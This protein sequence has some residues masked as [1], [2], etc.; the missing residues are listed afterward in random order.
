M[1]WIKRININTNNLMNTSLCLLIL[2]LFVN[3]SSKY[4]DDGRIYVGAFA[5]CKDASSCTNAC[6]TNQKCIQFRDNDGSTKNINN[7]PYLTQTC[8]QIPSCAEF[9]KFFAFQTDDDCST[10]CEINIFPGFSLKSELNNN[11]DLYN[12]KGYNMMC[13]EYM[14][15]KTTLPNICDIA[16]NME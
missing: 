14:D 15:T 2:V 13:I 16:K 1:F 6:E 11:V 9:P 7:L 4:E 8:W 10:D 12:A 5:I 3:V